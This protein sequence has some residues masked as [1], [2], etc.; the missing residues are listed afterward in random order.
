MGA[1]FDTTSVPAPASP[2]RSRSLALSESLTASP[3][4]SIRD[5]RTT[6]TVLCAPGPRCRSGRRSR[7]GFRGEESLEV[8]RRD[9]FERSKGEPRR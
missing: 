6:A 3:N 8:V 4:G 7:G 1:Q 9:G 2:P 5:L